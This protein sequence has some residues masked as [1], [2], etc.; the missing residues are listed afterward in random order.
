MVRV[1][2]EVERSSIEGGVRERL[3]SQ[4]GKETHEAMGHLP[5]NRLDDVAGPQDHEGA[6]Y[7][8]STSIGVLDGGRC[9]ESG[10]PIR[11]RGLVPGYDLG[12]D[13][14]LR[15]PN[16]VRSLKSGSKMPRTNCIE[17]GP[18]VKI[19]AAER[20]GQEAARTMLV[21]ADLRKA[22]RLDQALMKRNSCKHFRL[23]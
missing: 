17:F 5:E 2:V 1:R 8:G 12:I 20:P 13:T 16:E 10:E 14:P 9:D 22:S 21:Q 23:R 4:T 15:L 6:A 7:R 19:V 18:N 3:G 11:E